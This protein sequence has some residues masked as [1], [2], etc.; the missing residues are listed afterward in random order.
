MALIVV[1]NGVGSVGKS[2]LARAV[3]AR[4]GLPLLHV[5]MDGFLAMLPEALQDDP[6]GIAYRRG[7]AGVEVVVGPAGARLLDGMLGAVAALAEAGCDLVFDT[8]MD[9]ETVLACRRKL[10]AFDPVFVGLTAP[11]ALIEAREAGRG[12]RDIGLARAQ[13]GWVHVGVDDDLTLDMGVFSSD[14]AARV[15]CE[16]FGL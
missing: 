15:L 3:Q 6:A 5:A 4:A 7:A 13:V 10:A 11:L 16:R 2:S 1:L 9:R 12:D 8:V 14:A